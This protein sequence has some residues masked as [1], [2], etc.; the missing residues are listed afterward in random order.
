MTMKVEFRT[1]NKKSIRRKNKPTNGQMMLN[2]GKIYSFFKVSVEILYNISL[3]IK[4]TL[5]NISLGICCIE[6][7][8]RTQQNSETS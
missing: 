1:V 2:L 7:T 6:K 5:S 3:I 8:T 4:K